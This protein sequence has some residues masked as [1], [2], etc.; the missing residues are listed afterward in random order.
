MALPTRKSSVTISTTSSDH[1]GRNPTFI[2]VSCGFSKKISQATVLFT[3]LFLSANAIAAEIITT[4]PPLAGLVRMLD[5]DAET[6]CLLK[7]G[8][9]PHHFQLTP[10]QVENVGKASLLVRSS[11]DDQGWLRLNP[12]IPVIDLWPD[13][14]HGW[15]NPSSVAEAIPRLADALATA[16]PQRAEAIRQRLKEA[17]GRVKTISQALT[18]AIRSLKKRG[19]IVQHPSWRRVFEQNG[20]EVLDVLESERHGHELG[21]HHLEE[22]LAT[23]EAHPGAVLVGDLKHSNRSL[24]W[25]AGHAENATILYLDG[26]GKCGDDWPELMQQNIDRIRNR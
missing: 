17:L 11:R 3:L 24:Q 9:D 18:D 19:V 2:T 12:D 13:I 16:H 6:S 14:D 5:P 22:A 10:Q 7:A 20:V 4:L 1:S 23:L 8:S 15:L 21:A 26:L 25:L